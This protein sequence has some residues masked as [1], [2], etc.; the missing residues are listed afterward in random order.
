MLY[1]LARAYVAGGRYAEAERAANEFMALVTRGLASD[2]LTIG[3]A[4]L[5]L[6]QALAGQQRYREAL[7]HAKVAV[8]I[9]VS[10]ATSSSY[11]RQ[12]AA[13]AT[14]LAE[15]IKASSKL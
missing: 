7:P 4:H 15:T 5:V 3:V 10:G 14:H 8:D 11:A 1:F 9:L 6:G 12:T 13:E 2:S